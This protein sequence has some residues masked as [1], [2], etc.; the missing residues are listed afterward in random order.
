MV[1]DNGIVLIRVDHVHLSLFDEF[2]LFEFLTFIE[3]PFLI[4]KP[5]V[6][7]MF[8]GVEEVIIEFSVGLVLSLFGNASLDGGYWLFFIGV[9][10]CCSFGS[11]IFGEWLAAEG[12]GFGEG[13]VETGLADEVVLDCKG[14]RGYIASIHQKIIK[15]KYNKNNGN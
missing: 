12:T 5:M 6:E 2:D 15:Y 10:A 8:E 9:E 1:K 14:K 4:A 3:I 7:F 11:E 13:G